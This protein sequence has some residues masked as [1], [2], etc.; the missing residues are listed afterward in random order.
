MNKIERISAV[1]IIIGGIIPTSIGIVWIILPF[2]LISHLDKIKTEINE[3]N[4]AVMR[5]EACT[6]NPANR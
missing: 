1:L 4:V 2:L 5:Y 3:I 6:R